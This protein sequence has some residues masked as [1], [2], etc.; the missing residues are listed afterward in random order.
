M[1]SPKMSGMKQ[2]VSWPSEKK[3]NVGPKGE[4]L[5]FKAGKS[6]HF[7][8]WSKIFQIRANG[9]YLLIYSGNN[10]YKVREPLYRLI[11][12]LSTPPFV[13]ISR[14]TIINI[15]YIKEVRKRNCNSAEVFLSNNNVCFWSRSFF[16]ALDDLIDSV[17]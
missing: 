6:I 17:S 11:K 14:S 1:D 16:C 9:N 3:S 5:I 10:R 7:V 4:M 2:D 12:R 13:Q 15:T 8:E